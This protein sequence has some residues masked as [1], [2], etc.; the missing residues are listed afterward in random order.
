MENQELN[1]ESTLTES[2]LTV[3]VSAQSTPST[4]RVRELSMD[5]MF[6]LIKTMSENIS[7]DL[8]ELK[9]QNKE[10]QIDSNVKYNRMNEKFDVQKTS[11]D[12]LKN[13]INEINEH[14]NQT[15]DIIEN[16]CNRLEQSIEKLG[17][18]VIS[19]T[20]INNDEIVELSLIHI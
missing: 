6:N 10:Q 12:E 3:N 16:N 11:L 2:M 15:N 5:D 7:S 17:D 13:Q 8:N 4:T 19:M 1:L 20:N 18:K 14:L 9:K